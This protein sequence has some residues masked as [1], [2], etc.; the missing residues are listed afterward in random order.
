M[1]YLSLACLEQLSPLGVKLLSMKTFPGNNNSAINFAEFAKSTINNLPIR[2]KTMGTYHSMYR[3]HIHQALGDMDLREIKRSDIQE[4]IV[5]LAAQTSAMTL[6]VIKSIFREAMAQ[7]LIENSP[8]HGVKGKAIS[9]APRRFLTWAQIERSEFGPLKEHI[10]FLALHGL[11]WSEAVAL[12]KEDIRDGRIYINKSIHGQTKSRA[13]IR[14]VPLVS[15]FVKFPKTPKPL[16]RVLDPYQVQIHSLR[17]TYAYLLKSSGVHVTTA[18]RLL[19]H[20]D[21]KMTLAIY[22]QVLDHEIDDSGI[23]LRRWIERAQ[24]R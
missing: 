15:K 3:C 6:A 5:P 24:E 12:D 23:A 17:H 22:T 18:Q 1:F 7:A 4:L 2:R 13:A 16:R 10:H 21:P 19:G 20:S 9:V 8:A 11:R 14:T